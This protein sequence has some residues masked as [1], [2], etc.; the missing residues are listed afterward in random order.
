MVGLLGVL[1]AGG[2]YLPLDPSYPADRLGFMLEDARPRVILTQERLASGS[3]GARRLGCLPGRAGAGIRDA[4]PRYSREHGNGNGELPLPPDPTSLAYV[5]YTS[6]STGRPKGVQVSHRAVVNLLTSMR[7]EPGLAAEDTLLSVTT[8]G[9]DIAALELFLPLTTGACVVIAPRDV[10][11]DGRRLARL[12]EDSGTLGDASDPGDMANAA[13]RP[14]GSGNSNAQGALRWRST[15]PR[16]GR[17]IAIALRD[18]LEPLRSDRDHDLVRRVSGVARPADHA[19][20]GRSPIPGSMS[21][22]ASCSPC[23]LACRVSCSSAA[24]A[25]PR[26]FEPARVDR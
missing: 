9:F 17:S 16:P 5:L 8:L 26:L 19:L 21:S 20:A 12:L 1:K 4:G 7:R 23:R 11:V 2:A 13:R 6:G 3:S 14:A 24:T 10:V 25:G 15:D 22:I 18:A